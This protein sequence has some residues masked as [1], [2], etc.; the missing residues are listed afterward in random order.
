MSAV[1]EYV[2]CNRAAEGTDML[3]LPGS[4]TFP[5]TVLPGRPCGTPGEGK[6]INKYGLMVIGDRNCK[7]SNHSDEYQA[8]FSAVLERI[9]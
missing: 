2:C 6:K 1:L 8:Y 7:T 9:S 5:S 3:G 4:S